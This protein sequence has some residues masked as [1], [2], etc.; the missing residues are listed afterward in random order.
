MHKLICTGDISKQINDFE[1]EPNVLNIKYL[2]CIFIPLLQLY[3]VFILLESCRY[4]WYNNI[5]C[6]HKGIIL[7]LHLLLLIF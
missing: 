6:I 3:M 4:N 2:F 1:Y 7:S 5:L